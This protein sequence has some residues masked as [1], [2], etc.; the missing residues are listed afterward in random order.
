MTGVK[1]RGW[2]GWKNSITLN[3]CKKKGPLAGLRAVK[4]IPKKRE[5]TRVKT[6]QIARGKFWSVGKGSHLFGNRGLAFLHLNASGGGSRHRRGENTPSNEKSSKGGIN[7]E[8]GGYGEPASPEKS[9]FS[10]KEKLRAYFLRNHL[11][12][13]ASRE[14][15]MERRISRGHSFARGYLKGVA[16][17]ESCARTESSVYCRIGENLHEIGGS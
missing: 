6:Y 3:P 16:F 8:E 7:S 4:K 13:E 17:E 10:H 1:K 15:N 2:K 5:G 14:E 9:T 11:C 12:I